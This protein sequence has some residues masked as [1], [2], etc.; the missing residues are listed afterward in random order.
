MKPRKYCDGLSGVPPWQ[1]TPLSLP[2]SHPASIVKVNAPL[3]NALPGLSRYLTCMLSSVCMR[4]RPGMPSV[5]VPQYWLPRTET[6]PFGRHKICRPRPGAL[7]NL[8]Y[9]CHP[10]TIQGSI[11][12]LSLGN[13]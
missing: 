5:S 7:L 8:P 11:F 9:D 10:L 12:S 6:E 4:L 2:Y 13:I 1:L 3:L